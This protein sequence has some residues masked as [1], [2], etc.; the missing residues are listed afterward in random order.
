[1]IRL[2][3]P[4]RTLPP[5]TNAQDTPDPI[6]DSANAGRHPHDPGTIGKPQRQAI[7]ARVFAQAR[8]CRAWPLRTFAARQAADGFIGQHALG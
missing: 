6:G 5:Q 4:P 1:M 3:R 2:L 8:A 7:V